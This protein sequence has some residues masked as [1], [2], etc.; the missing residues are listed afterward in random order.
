[1]V[2]M[3]SGTGRRECGR[4]FAWRVTQDGGSH[5][6]STISEFLTRLS[7]NEPFCNHKSI[8]SLIA[9]NLFYPFSLEKSAIW[10]SFTELITEQ[11]FETLK[12]VPL[13]I[14]KKSLKKGI[15]GRL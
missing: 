13:S 7:M 6:I 2:A 9:Y 10:Q 5:D 3:A 12:T 11:L 15:L 1:M 8:L 4:C 14:R